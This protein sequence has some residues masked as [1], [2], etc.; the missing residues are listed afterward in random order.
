MNIIELEG[1]SQEIALNKALEE[2]NASEREVIYNYEE[3]AG[4]I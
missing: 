3:I 1:K 4:G 2:A